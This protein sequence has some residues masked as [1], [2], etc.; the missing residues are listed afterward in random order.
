MGEGDA[1]GAL[2]VMNSVGVGVRG[3]ALVSATLAGDAEEPHA[4]SA[5]PRS[6]VSDL[7]L[8]RVRAR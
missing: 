6:N 8:L 3:G 7:T 2:V 5:S 1:V 4:T